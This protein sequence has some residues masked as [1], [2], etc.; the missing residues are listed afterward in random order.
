MEITNT[1]IVLAALFIAGFAFLLINQVKARRSAALEISDIKAEVKKEIKE[2]RFTTPR[3]YKNSKGE[4][5][6]TSPAGEE[7][8]NYQLKPDK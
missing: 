2:L 6:L 4:A 8:H 7:I 1:D 5:I 3:Y